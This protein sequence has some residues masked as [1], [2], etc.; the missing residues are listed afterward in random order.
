VLT[1][2]PALDKQWLERFNKHEGSSPESYIL[3][4]PGDIIVAEQLHCYP[5]ATKK[6]PEWHKDGLAYTRLAFEQS[7]GEA[8]AKYKAGLVTT[9]TIWDLTGGLGIDSYAFSQYA[10]HVH[11]C[12]IAEQPYLL[13]KNNHAI[14]GA[15]NIKHH[16]ISA[17]DA[18]NMVKASEWVFIDPSRRKSTGRTFLLKDCDP[19]VLDLLPQLRS[20]NANVLLKLSPL[21]DLQQLK[22]EIPELT[23]IYVVSV[24][25]EVKEIIVEICSKPKGYVHSVCLPD[26]I[27]FRR[28][29]SGNKISS[30]PKTTSQPANYILVADAAIIKA[31]TFRNILE[32]YPVTLWGKSIYLTSTVENIP[33][34]RSYEVI[35]TVEYKPKKL[36][37]YLGGKKVNIHKR[38]F[39]IE[40]SQL[41]KILGV[42]MGDDYHL[43]FTTDTNGDR[44]V[45]VTHP[46]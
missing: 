8:T 3:A 42:S 25:G 31:E 34:C 39:P 44:L 20:K 28:G 18:V 38:N 17:E 15:T 5:K 32:V 23:N 6:F 13:A 4:N 19:N 16:H 1:F 7:S 40:V 37:S 9:D 11:Y 21:Y 35:D 29:L 30:P 12:E 36:K 27:E 46:A 43:F 33:G 41:Y 45:C 2:D 26:K 14:W 22:N 24:D 10:R